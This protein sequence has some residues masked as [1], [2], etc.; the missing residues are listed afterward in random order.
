M[1]AS[2]NFG[3]KEHKLRQS[4]TSASAW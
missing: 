2:E 1:V 3:D 4:N